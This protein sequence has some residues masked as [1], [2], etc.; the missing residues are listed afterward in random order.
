MWCLCVVYVQTNYSHSLRSVRGYVSDGGALAE[1]RRRRGCCGLASSR[2]QCMCNPPN[3][4][5]RLLATT[6]Y[7]TEGGAARCRPLNSLH[8]SALKPA[9]SM[10]S[11][12]RAIELAEGRGARCTQRRSTYFG[13]TQ[14]VPESLAL[15][16][17]PHCLFAEHRSVGRLGGADRGGCRRLR[18]C[19]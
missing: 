9:D 4:S 10:A 12:R 17:S 13:H 11:F 7:R 8:R 14:R 16:K 3:R 2:C 18:C 1:S 19:W 6:M 5:R 15:L